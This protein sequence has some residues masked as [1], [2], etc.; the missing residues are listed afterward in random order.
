MISRTQKLPNVRCGIENTCIH[1]EW[2]NGRKKKN[3]N[4]QNEH[5]TR[6]QKKANENDEGKIVKEKHNAKQ[7]GH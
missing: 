2:S 5:V 6:T 4:K 7:Y 1:L 3:K